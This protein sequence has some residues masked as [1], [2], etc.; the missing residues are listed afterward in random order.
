MVKVGMRGGKSLLTK[1]QIKLP[2][3]QAFVIFEEVIA[4]VQI[5]NSEISKYQS[6][7][8]L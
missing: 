6:E 2:L 3:Q 7:T 1:I 8:N 4:L 5:G